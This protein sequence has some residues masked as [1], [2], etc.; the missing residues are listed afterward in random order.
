MLPLFEA[1]ALKAAKK[2][3]FPILRDAGNEESE[4]AVPEVQIM[5]KSGL[6]ML[7]F[8]DLTVR[9]LNLIEYLLLD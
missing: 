8:R 4:T 1:A 9:V 7:Q 2:I 6:N 5:V 3:L